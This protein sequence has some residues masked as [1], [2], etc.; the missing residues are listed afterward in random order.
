[1]NWGIVIGIM[2]VVLGVVGI[3][4]AVYQRR[5]SRRIMERMEAMLRQVMDGSFRP[6]GYDE[7]LL[8]ALENTMKEFLRSSA[9]GAARVA[10]ERD[11]IKTFIADISH[12]TKTP[13]ANILL[14]SQ[15]LTESNDLTPEDRRAAEALEGQAGKLSFLIT[16]LVKLSRLETGILTV[17][18][19]RGNL[20]EL[21]ETAVRQVLPQAEAKGVSLTVER[22]GTAGFGTAAADAADTVVAADTAA[23][24]DA[25]ADA[26]AVFDMKWTCEALYNLLENAVKYTEPGG[27]IIVRIRMYEMFGCVEV[28]D[29]GEGIPEEDISRI[30]GRFFRGKNGREK[31]GLGIGLFL[32]REIVSLEGGYIK[33]KSEP[34]RGSVFSVFLPRENGKKAEA[35]KEKNEVE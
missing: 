30:F 19:V 28:E 35:L 13:M 7:S 31:E 23:A 9:L 15:L 6:E 10:E 26:M 18:P 34:G 24:V 2:G 27:H 32:A 4:A 1:M 25:T 17:D 21:M 20:R 3:G 29:T 12:Q 11:H 5:E 33:V 22:A 14:Y 8:S 16:S